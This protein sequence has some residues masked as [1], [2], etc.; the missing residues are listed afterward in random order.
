MFL[1]S[2]KLSQATVLRFRVDSAWS[3]KSEAGLK[4]LLGLWFLFSSP[5]PKDSKT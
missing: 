1:Q 5:R 3:P 4:E 2:L